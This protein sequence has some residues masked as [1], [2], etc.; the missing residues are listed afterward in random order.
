MGTCGV[1][2]AKLM[3]KEDSPHHAISRSSA[4]GVRGPKTDR[5]AFRYM[6]L[7]PKKDVIAQFLVQDSIAEVGIKGTFHFN[8]CRHLPSPNGT[9]LR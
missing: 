8:N 5:R 7:R 1:I 4:H 6:S 2:D 9:Q 3:V